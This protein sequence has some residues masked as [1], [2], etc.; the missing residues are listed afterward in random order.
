VETSRKIDWLRLED[1]IDPK[2][3]E[4]RTMS[5]IPMDLILRNIASEIDRLHALSIA[6]DELS[7]ELT[8][9]RYWLDAVEKGK[10][11]DE[12]SELFLNFFM[13]GLKVGEMQ[14]V[15]RGQGAIE[16]AKARLTTF[17]QSLPLKRK[18]SIQQSAKELAQ[19][20]AATKWRLREYE[21]FR[22]AEMADLVWSDLVDISARHDALEKALPNSAKGLIPWLREIAPT[23]ARKPGRPKKS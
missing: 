4:A 23:E 18:A 3:G 8:N 6:G 9:L 14:S 2:T 22:L 11:R 15:L 1:T 16:A 12:F 5:E 10:S 19:E 13:L 20:I 21:Q 17:E 7:I